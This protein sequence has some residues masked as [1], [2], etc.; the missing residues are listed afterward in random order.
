MEMEALMEF[1][2]EFSGIVEKKSGLIGSIV[3]ISE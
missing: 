3:E 1:I 2:N